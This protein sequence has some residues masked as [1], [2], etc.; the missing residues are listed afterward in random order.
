M[1]MDNMQVIHDL[2]TMQILKSKENQMQMKMQRQ[3][4]DMSEYKDGNIFDNIQKYNN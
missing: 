3:I 1:I 2:D 4:M